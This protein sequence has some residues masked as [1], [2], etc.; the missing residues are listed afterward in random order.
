M[1]FFSNLVVFLLTF[2]PL[3]GYTQNS[4]DQEILEKANTAK[5]ISYL[6]EEEKQIIFY[7]N[8]LRLQPKLFRN[9]FVKHYIDSTGSKSKYVKSLL[10]TLETQPSLPVLKPSERL[11]KI[12]KEH[13]TTF[14]KQGKAGHGNFK[15]RFQSYLNDCKCAIAENCYYG[16]VSAL[17]VVI[18]LLID[19]N[20]S[21]LGHRKNLLNP[22]LINTGVCIS[23][24]KKYKKNCVADYSSAVKD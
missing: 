23:P 8:L 2:V 24:H 19:E 7:T 16:N 10:K 4:W 3:C 12:A 21:N 18:G 9:T 15:K 14:G 22:A 5:D 13:A 11:Y 1:R 17:D 20:I 6:T